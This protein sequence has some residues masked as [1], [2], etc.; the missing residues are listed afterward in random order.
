MKYGVKK[1][2]VIVMVIALA[3]AFVGCKSNTPEPMQ[4]SAG[5][6]PVQPAEKAKIRVATL[7]GPTG[8]GM[9]YLMERNENKESALEYDFTLLG[10]P[11]DLTGKVLSGEVDVAAVPTNLA[12]VLYNRTQGAVQIAA[13]NTLGVLYLVENGNTINTIED[14]RGQSVYSSGKGAAPD[15][16]FRHILEENQLTVDQDVMVDYKLQHAELAAAL[17]A[18]DVNIALLPQPHVT[19]AMIKNPNLRIALDITEEWN[20]IKGDQENLPMGSIIVQRAYLEKNK[21]AFDKF[22]YEYKESVDYVNS[23][24]DASAE[25]I[26]KFEILPQAPIAKKAIPYSSIVYIDAQEAKSHLQSFYQILFN[27]EPKSVGGKL[28]DEEFYYKK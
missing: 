10:S 19:T 21:E 15:F 14:L 28:P 24:I 17:A 16:V 2:V 20:K 5:E 4:P 6:N 22:L 7:K 13:V 8:M 27:F 25:L 1:L 26:A 9:A 11:D 3:V 23:K 18:G 12:A